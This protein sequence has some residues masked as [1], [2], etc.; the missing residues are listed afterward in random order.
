[1]TDSTTTEAPAE[2]GLTPGQQ[3]IL[4][5][6]V[7]KARAQ[8]S[9]TGDRPWWE[10][11]VAVA[12][13]AAGLGICLLVLGAAV[14]WLRLVAAGLPAEQG[15]AAVSKQSLAVVGAHVLLVPAI[16]S[17][18]GVIGVHY[19]TDLSIRRT[20][21]AIDAGEPAPVTLEHAQ[22]ATEKLNARLQRT[23]NWLNQR[24]VAKGA[25]LAIFVPFWPLYKVSEFL[26]RRKLLFL[27][28]VAAFPPVPT[29]I[30]LFVLYSIAWRWS[31]HVE[32]T[33]YLAGRS[34]RKI[35]GLTLL[36]FALAACGVALAGQFDQPSQLAPATVTLISGSKVTG[37]FVASDAV[38]VTLSLDH[39]LRVISRPDIASLSIGHQRN[40]PVPPSLERDLFEAVF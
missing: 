11:V 28:W 30:A 25:V 19:W 36:G 22:R 38:A 1:M 29:W 37:L 17:T 5:L 33:S 4:S 34:L 20:V 39:K 6:Q 16:I 15:L 7:D 40:V 31:E 21:K 14:T 12:G 23:S 24:A 35:R 2:T 10:I 27:W 8:G 32:A 18:V 13:A 9:P 3:Y 26:R